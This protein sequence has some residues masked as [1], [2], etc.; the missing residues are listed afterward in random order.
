[1][2]Y[3]QSKIYNYIRNRIFFRFIGIPF[4]YWYTQRYKILDSMSSIRYIIDN[5]CSVSRY[6]DGEFYV[7]MGLGNGFQTPNPRLAAR[8]I[9]VFHSMDAPNH[10]VGIPK[11]IQD[12]STLIDDYPTF[13]WRHYTCRHFLFLKRHISTSRTY[14]N[15]QLSRFYYEVKDK[16]RCGDQLN[17]LKQVWEGRNIVI[18][19]G[20][21]TRS[22]I[23]N[24]LYDNAKS[25][26][27]ILGPA[28]NAFDKYD[29]M[30]AAIKKHVSK[31]TLVL[32]CYG[33]TATVLAYDLARLGYWA[34]DLGHLDIEYEW[35][36][37][38]SDGR[39]AIKG[40][41]TNE[42]PQ[43]GGHEVEE[44]LDP[45]YIKQIIYRV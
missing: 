1:M 21:K 40:K 11:P 15:T 28:T 2:H 32:L 36:L 41:F 10:M 45:K 5:K 25:L 12:T 37:A 14:L 13:F 8:L 9:E 35:C 19:E 4:A 26:K 23:G 38:K 17:L 43:D 18:I 3:S 24:D 22:G 39:T 20:E 16:S 27:R 7:M 44:C 29:E 30:L 33:M 6:G 31:D 34:I 42:A